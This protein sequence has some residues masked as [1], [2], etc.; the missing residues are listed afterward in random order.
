MSLQKLFVMFRFDKSWKTVVIHK[1]KYVILRHLKCIVVWVTHILVDFCS[2]FRIDAYLQREIMDGA[3]RHVMRA[4]VYLKVAWCE[5]S[6]RH[7][8]LTN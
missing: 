2:H 6:Q 3:V 8:A 5:Y 1:S 7:K 4:N